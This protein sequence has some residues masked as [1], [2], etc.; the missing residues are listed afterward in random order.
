VNEARRYDLT[1][2][3]TDGWFERVLGSVPALVQLCEA[4]GDALVALS[5]AAGVRILSATVDPNAGTVRSLQWA[6]DGADGQEHAREGTPETLRAEVLATLLAEPDAPPPPPGAEATALRETIGLRTALL[7]PLFGLRLLTLHVQGDEVRVTVGHDRGEE[8]VAL[9]QL[10]R[11]LRSR[12]VEALQPRG[13]P[14]TFDLG[15]IA[16]ARDDLAAGRFENVIGR[17]GGWVTPLTMILRTPEGQAMPPAQRAEMARALGL[18]GAA[19]EGLQRLDEAEEVLRLGTQWSL[20]GEAAADAYGALAMCLVRQD[21]RPESIG[22]LRRA[23]TFDPGRAALRVELARGFLSAGRAVAAL[24]LLRALRREGVRDEALQALDAELRARLGE[25]LV[26]YESA[27]VE[28][29]P[30]AHL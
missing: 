22:L 16:L 29:P 13:K 10:R 27:L 17:L 11:F 2:V 14:F 20:D 6:R 28:A 26:R 5:L 19:L 23:L 7:A 4:L 30:D 15:A 1:A 3:A 12:A 25:A 21:R 24:G 8:T 9:R 18:L